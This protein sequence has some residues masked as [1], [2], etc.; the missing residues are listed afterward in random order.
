M[1][2]TQRTL[3]PG[4][5]GTKKLLQQ[6][7]KQLICVRYKYNPETKTRLKTIELVIEE[8][9]WKPQPRHIPKNKFM[10]LRIGTHEIQLNTMIR[11][12]GGRWNH[13]HK[14]WELPYRDILELGLRD[15]I[16]ELRG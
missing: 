7:G 13:E 9:P 6:H 3:L 12:A 8:T 5:P 1:I 16:I 14:V 2:K 4:Q 10:L 11:A 15:R